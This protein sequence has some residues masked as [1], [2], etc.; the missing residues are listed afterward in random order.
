MNVKVRRGLGGMSAASCP[1]L[2]PCLMEARSE[3]Q[4]V[5]VSGWGS[6][7]HCW[8]RGPV[9]R[10]VSPLLS[11]CFH[12]SR[13]SAPRPASLVFK[14]VPWVRT[15][16]HAIAPGSTGAGT[17]HRQEVPE[18]IRRA[19]PGASGGGRWAGISGEGL[20]ESLRG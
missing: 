18:D 16:A 2:A 5:P 20:D 4:E 12:I 19:S 10:L 1:S 9:P 7:R 17:G 15:R 14:V 13:V 11:P 8:H 6:E 3:V